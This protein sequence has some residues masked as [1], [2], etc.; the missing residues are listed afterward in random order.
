MFDDV[1]HS[2]LLHYV[3][4]SGESGLAHAYELGRSALT[5]GDS[6]LH[7]VSVHEKALSTIVDATPSGDEARRRVQLSSRFLLEALSPFEL[8]IHRA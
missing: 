8:M 4:G 1:Y 7:V 2:A 5:G 3:Q 6:L